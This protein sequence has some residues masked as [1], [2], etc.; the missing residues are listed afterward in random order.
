[1]YRLRRLPIVANP[2]LGVPMHQWVLD[3]DA[4]DW[5]VPERR[6]QFGRL[7][8]VRPH[9]LQPLSL[10]WRVQPTEPALAQPGARRMEHGQQVPAVAQVVSRVAY[11]VPVA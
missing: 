3:A 8:E 4:R 7:V 9:R 5:C 11:D 10:G 6:E 1:M 2:R